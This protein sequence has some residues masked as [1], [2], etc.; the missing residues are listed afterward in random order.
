MTS[1]IIQFE[2]FVLS[3]YIYLNLRENK[4]FFF[5]LSPKVIVF[6]FSPYFHNEQIAEKVIYVLEK[7]LEE[8][9]W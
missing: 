8:N 1:S 2:I 9:V 7:D 4:T 3:I 5:F 6:K